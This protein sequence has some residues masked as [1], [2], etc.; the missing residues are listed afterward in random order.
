[1]MGF[2]CKI[3]HPSQNINKNWLT[4]VNVFSL[5]F[6]LNTYCTSIYVD[7]FLLIF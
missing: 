4:K 5:K 6:V 3:L 7:I 2:I 1:M